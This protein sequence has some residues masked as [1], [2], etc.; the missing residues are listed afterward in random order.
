MSTD[1]N[2][3]KEKARKGEKTKAE[4]KEIPQYIPGNPWLS[5][6]QGW[7]PEN[8]GC[9]LP[10]RPKAPTPEPD[11]VVEI[12]L[13]DDLLDRDGQQEEPSLPYSPMSPPKPSPAAKSSSAKRKTNTQ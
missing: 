4:R 2:L 12:V 13:L 1:S 5:I 10:A 9:E 6:Q 11:S 7:C 8:D 3:T